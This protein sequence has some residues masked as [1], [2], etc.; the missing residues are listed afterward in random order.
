MAVREGEVL[1]RD[2]IYCVKPVYVNIQCWI[3][4]SKISYC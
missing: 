4:P 1:Q 3:Y 2:M